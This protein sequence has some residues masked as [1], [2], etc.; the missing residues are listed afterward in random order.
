[1]SDG[2]PREPLA[3]GAIEPAEDRDAA[4]VIGGDHGPTRLRRAPD[5]PDTG[6]NQ[7]LVS[8]GGRV[9]VRGNDRR[10][11]PQLGTAAG[12][13]SRRSCSTAVRPFPTTWARV[14]RGLRDL[15]DDPVHAARSAALGGRPAVHH[16]VARVRRRRRAR[17][18]RDRP[19]LGDRSLVGRPPRPPP[20]SPARGSPAGTAADRPARCRPRGVHGAG[21][22]PTSRHD[23]EERGRV[24]EI[25]ERRRGGEATEEDL[26]ER[27]RLVWPHYFVKE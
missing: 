2:G 20:R 14:P 10:R 25:E 12:R 17:L 16:R 9:D 19:R 11:H 23:G 4:D 27:L 7:Y 3:V 13:V 15:R 24:D 18:A 26:L 8:P 22:K 6:W 1:M 5:R 21:R